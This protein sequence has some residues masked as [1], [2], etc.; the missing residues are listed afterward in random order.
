[1]KTA[2]WWVGQVGWVVLSVAC[3]ALCVMDL[4][5]DDEDELDDEEDL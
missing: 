3:P 4:M 1:M 5:D 2:W